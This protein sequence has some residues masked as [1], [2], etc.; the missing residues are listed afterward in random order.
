MNLIIKHKDFVIKYGLKLLPVIILGAIIFDLIRHDKIGISLD[1]L[2]KQS[3]S[4]EQ[5][6]WLIPIVGLMF[7]NWSFEAFKWK[8]LIR[9][10]YSM[11]FKNAFKSIWSGVSTALTSPNR[12][13]DFV[14]KV[15]HLPKKYRKKGVLA[16]FYSSYSQ[17]LITL[18]MGWIGW[19]YF[20]NIIIQNSFFKSVISVVGIVLALGLAFLFFYDKSTQ[21]LPDKWKKHFKSSPN[22]KTK[23]IITGFSLLRYIAFATQFYLLFR[24][25]GLELEYSSVFL[26]ITLF[27]LITSFVPASF[28]GELGIKESVAV[29]VFSGLVYN[30]LIIIVATILLWLINLVIPALI[31]NYFLFKINTDSE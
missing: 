29:W 11:S 16:S 19:L 20:G 31:G 28:F 23:I 17:W 30:S 9:P 26:K 1:F 12:L 25:L 4:K 8:Q 2:Q 22:V 21:L 14:G 27:Y 7:L 10:F 6:L 13:A 24:F 15:S 18:F 3:W 5:A